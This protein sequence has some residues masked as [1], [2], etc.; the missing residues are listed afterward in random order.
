MSVI[1]EFLFTIAQFILP[2]HLLSRLIG[3]IAEC[4]WPW[5]KNALIKQFI[6]AY[7]V[8]MAEAADP[9]PE[10]YACFNDFFTRAL[11]SDARELS[12]HETEIACPADGA[13]S[14]IGDIEKGRIF[15]A[16]GYDFSTRELLGG[17]EEL[18]EQFEDG[19]FATIYLSPKDYHRVHMPLAGELKQMVYVPGRLFSV[20]P[21]TVNQIPRLFARNERMVALF[22][23]KHGP[24]AMVMVGA[25]IVASIETVWGG[26]VTPPKRQLQQFDYGKPVRLDRGEEMGQFKLGS[27]VIMLFGKD[28]ISWDNDLLADQSVRLGQKLGVIQD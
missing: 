11:K 21:L 18:A 12:E 2:H 10:S 13:I 25:M 28:M 7:K 15:Q 26:L 9:K 14:Q 20:S 16:K 5:L 17:S 1:K 23:T 3:Y 8:N 6:S 24:M 27:T 19:K 4:R 22:E